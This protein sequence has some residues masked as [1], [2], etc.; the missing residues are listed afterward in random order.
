MTG[1]ALVTLLVVD[2]AG[3][4]YKAVVS[5]GQNPGTPPFFAL[6]ASHPGRR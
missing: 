2:A 1:E 4:G 5:P 6:G 3:L